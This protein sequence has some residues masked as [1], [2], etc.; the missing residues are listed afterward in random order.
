MGAWWMS[1]EAGQGQPATRAVR[2]GL[3]EV[4][5]PVLT[6]TSASKSES[7]SWPLTLRGAGLADDAARRALRDREPLL[8]H[9]DGPTAAVRG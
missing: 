1:V 7:K 6:G 5:A 2:P 3:V 4:D 8:E 9:D